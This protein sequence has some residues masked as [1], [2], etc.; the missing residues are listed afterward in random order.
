[1]ILRPG[2]LQAGCCLRSQGA[3]ASRESVRPL[4]ANGEEADDGT[5]SLLAAADCQAGMQWD[6]RASGACC[7]GTDVTVGVVGFCSNSG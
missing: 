3:H 1:M 5:M 4:V 2:R 6:L 7:A